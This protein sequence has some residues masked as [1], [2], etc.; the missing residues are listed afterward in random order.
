MN[1]GGS[2]SLNRKKD[3][4]IPQGRVLNVPF[5]LGELRNE[6]DGSL[7]AENLTIYIKTKNQKVATRALQGV[8]KQLDAWQWRDI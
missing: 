6:V 5:F 3:L 4:V 8:T 1:V 7:F 2:I